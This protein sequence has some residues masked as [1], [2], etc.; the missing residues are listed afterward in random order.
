[1]KN[2]YSTTFKRNPKKGNESHINQN[3]RPQSIRFSI[4]VLVPQKI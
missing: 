4:E 3:T 1:M 2:N